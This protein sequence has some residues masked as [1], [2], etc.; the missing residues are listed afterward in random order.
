MKTIHQ[1]M[2]DIRPA[3]MRLVHGLNSLGMRG[4]HIHAY[5]ASAAESRTDDRFGQFDP[6]HAAVLGAGMDAPTELPT[7]SVKAFIHESHRRAIGFCQRT[8]TR[9]GEQR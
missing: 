6:T 8:T 4:R 9:P 5:S 1:M 2:A 7:G 3:N